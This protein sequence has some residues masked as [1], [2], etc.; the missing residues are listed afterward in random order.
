[1]DVRCWLWAGFWGCAA[2]N[3][4]VEPPYG[5]ASLMAM[6]TLYVGVM[7]VRADSCDVICHTEL[8][9]CFE[10]S[11]AILFT[12]LWVNWY[13][14]LCIACHK[15]G[16]RQMMQPWLRPPTLRIRSYVRGI[17]K[18]TTSKAVSH[19]PSGGPR[20]MLRWLIQWEVSR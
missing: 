13:V 12:I 4:D 3:D 11:S 2:V 18:V 10:G 15:N 20:K 5:D 7:G 9:S 16:R 8:F 1:M 19:S 6:T 17:F 14:V